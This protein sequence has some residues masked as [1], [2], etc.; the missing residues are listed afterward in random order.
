MEDAVH[1]TAAPGCAL[2]AKKKHV[3]PSPPGADAC[4]KSDSTNIEDRETGKAATTLG[5]FV[6]S[7]AKMTCT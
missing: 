5:A 1:T 3:E 7:D 2:V 4:E 6:A